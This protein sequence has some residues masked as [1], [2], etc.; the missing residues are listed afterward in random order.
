MMSDYAHGKACKGGSVKV[1]EWLHKRKCLFNGN[2]LSMAA[3]KGNEK[4]V[5]WLLEHGAEKDTGSCT[6]AIKEGY[7]DIAKKLYVS[8]EYRYISCTAARAGSIEYLEWMFA[9][10]SPV[11][12]E[13]LRDEALKTG[14]LDLLKWLQ[15]KGCT[16]ETNVAFSYEAVKSGSIEVMQWLRENGVEWDCK[17]MTYAAVQGHLDLVK[18]MRENGCP[19]NSST[20][21]AVAFKCRKLEVLQW[22]I[23]NSCPYELQTTPNDYSKTK[24]SS[25]KLA[26]SGRSD[27]IKYL[28]KYGLYLDSSC[29][30]MDFNKKHMIPYFD[31]LYENGCTI[32]K[33][34]WVNAIKATNVT[35]LEWLKSKNC[36]WDTD[37]VYN[38]NIVLAIP[39]LEW[40]QQ[41]GYEMHPNASAA[42][43]RS[44]N[45]AVLKWMKQNGWPLTEDICLTSARLD[46]F[47][48]FKW[49]VEAGCPVDFEACEQDTGSEL[50]IEY[51]NELKN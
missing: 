2:A 24:I 38:R 29:Y 47:E 14:Q 1:L 22:L 45:M 51:I 4:A 11:P 50:I 9:Q 46:N 26:T 28:R 20:T 44:D 33:S 31:W 30:E 12:L 48:M 34:L 6:T 16:F 43:V 49:A 41:N 8:T 19:W 5:D 40:I 27:V 32:P 18:W 17:T 37:T 35:L 15:A 36:P 23:E 39:V 13:S 7:L 25:R 10:G 42:A 3:S 21:F